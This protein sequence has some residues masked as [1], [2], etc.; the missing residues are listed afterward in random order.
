MLIAATFP[1][2]WGDSDCRK[3]SSKPV[4]AVSDPTKVRFLCESSSLF[5]NFLSGEGQGGENFFVNES[6]CV[7][8]W[9][10]YVGLGVGGVLVAMR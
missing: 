8:S 2:S 3:A 9:G 1:F 4:D 5:P 10:G 7:S 6:K